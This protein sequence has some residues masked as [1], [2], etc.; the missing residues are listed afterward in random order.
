VIFRA[1]LAE[2]NPFEAVMA[3][4][5]WTVVFEKP[6]AVELVH[7]AKTGSRSIAVDG[8]W[9]D[10]GAKGKQFIDTGSIH[11]FAIDG[12]P[13]EVHIEPVGFG[14]WHYRLKADGEWLDPPLPPKRLPAWAFLFVALALLPLVHFASPDAS[15]IA[16]ILA[17]SAAL[18]ATFGIL[19]NARDPLL[20][21]ERKVLQCGLL[22]ALVWGVVALPGLM[23]VGA[24]KL[25]NG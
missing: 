18:G 12:R 19:A 3:R 5:V 23:L 10:L 20:S 9:L 11:N 22:A 2:G 6:H 7:G 14:R 25:L 4:K 17:G 8:E 16:W 13:V 24:V 21:V 1:T 15:P